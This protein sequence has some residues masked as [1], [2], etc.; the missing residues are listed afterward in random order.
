MDET[1]WTPVDVATFYDGSSPMAD[2]YFFGYQ[3][4]GYW[5]DEN[6]DTPLD[7][8][9]KRLTRKVVDTLGL[10]SGENVLDAGCGTGVTTVHIAGEYGVQVTGITLS[11]VEVATAQAKASESGLSDQARF[12]VADFHAQ[13]Y[14]ENHF[15]AIVAIEALFNSFDLE[16]AL[17]EFLRVLR[18]GGRVAIAE[19]TKTRAESPVGQPFPSARAPM[20]A[21]RWIQEFES[22]GFVIEELTHCGRR[23]Y[24]NSG[25]RYLNRHQ[26]VSD[27]LNEEFGEEMTK[28]IGKGMQE[29]F[30]LGP[31]DVGYLILCARKP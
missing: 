13:P 5:Y 27:L 6:D 2:K 16:K 11:P 17:L 25:T 10:R 8:A 29:A 24:A 18:P 1:N 31:E 20:L 12:E 30:H 7:E 22:A 23:V 9:Q 19:M 4:L 26:E 28:E 15:D 3:H 21:D 14:P